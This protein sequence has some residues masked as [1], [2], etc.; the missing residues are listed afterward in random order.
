MDGLIGLRVETGNKRLERKAKMNTTKQELVASVAKQIGLTQADAKIAVEALLEVLSQRLE[1]QETV[2]I[3]GFG[4][5]Y[6]KMRKPRPARNLKTGEV[7]PL[8]KRLVPLFKYA[9]STK[10]SI[11]EKLILKASDI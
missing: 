10:K 7:V 11:N 9:A 8:H 6:T 3:R 4:T 2:E 5:F 1:K